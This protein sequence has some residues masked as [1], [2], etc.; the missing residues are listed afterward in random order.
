[1]VLLTM[2][3]V[4]AI[5]VSIINLEGW[6]LILYKLSGGSGSATKDIAT[7]QLINIRNIGT[8]EQTTNNTNYRPVTEQLRLFHDART[9]EMS[10]FAIDEHE[11]CRAWADVAK[12]MQTEYV[13]MSCDEQGIRCEKI[14]CR[15]SCD[16]VSIP[17]NEVPCKM[18]QRRTWYD[19][20]REEYLDHSTT[21][22]NRL[23]NEA[24]FKMF[25]FG[26]VHDIIAEYVDQDMVYSVLDLLNNNERSSLIREAE[27]HQGVLFAISKDHV[28]V[29][30]LM[31]YY[32]NIATGRKDYAYVSSPINQTF[33]EKLPDYIISEAMDQLYKYDDEVDVD[34]WYST[35]PSHPEERKVSTSKF[36][37]K[38]SFELDLRDEVLMNKTNVIDYKL[39]GISGDDRSFILSLLEGGL[40]KEAIKK[41][42]SSL[43]LDGNR[44]IPSDTEVVSSLADEYLLEP[45]CTRAIKQWLDDLREMLTT[46][47]ANAEYEEYEYDVLRQIPMV[48]QGYF[49]DKMIDLVV[50]KVDG[51]RVGEG[52][53]SYSFRKLSFPKL[54]DIEK[55]DRVSA[56][57][58][59]LLSDEERTKILYRLDKLEARLLQSYKKPLAFDFNNLMGFFLKYELELEESE[60]IFEEETLQDDDDD[61]DDDEPKHENVTRQEAQQLLDFYQKVLVA[62][63][64][65]GGSEVARGRIYIDMFTQLDDGDEV[66]S[67]VENGWYEIKDILSPLGPDEEYFNWYNIMAY[68]ENIVTGTELEYVST[69]VLV[70]NIDMLERFLPHDYDADEASNPTNDEEEV[71][72][73][74]SVM[75]KIESVLTSKPHPDLDD[76]WKWA[77]LSDTM[78]F[79]VCDRIGYGNDLVSMLYKTHMH[80]MMIRVAKECHIVQALR[81]VLPHYDDWKE[82][83]RRDA[84]EYMVSKVSITY[85]ERSY[86][87]G[88]YIDA[89]YPNI[90]KEK[91][92]VVK[93]TTY[94]ERLF[95]GMLYIIGLLITLSIVKVCQIVLPKK[96]KSMKKPKHAKKKDK[97]SIYS[98]LISSAQ[99][100]HKMVL[101][102]SSKLCGII[103]KTPSLLL[104][105]VLIAFDSV[106]ESVR[107]TTNASLGIIKHL[108]T[109][110]YSI[111]R[112]GIQCLVVIP[113]LI[114]I[115]IGMMIR[116]PS[117]LIR[118]AMGTEH[119]SIEQPSNSSPQR[120]GAPQLIMSPSSA[121]S[122]IAVDEKKVNSL[123]EQNTIRKLEAVHDDSNNNLDEESPLDTAP[124]EEGVPSEIGIVN[125][126]LGMT[127]ETITEVSISSFNDKSKTSKTLSSFELNENDPLLI[128]LRS[129][130]A[131]IKGSVDEFFTWLVKY[132]NIESMMALKEAVSDD[133]YLNDT[134][135]IGD[136]SYGVKGFKLKSFRYAIL[137]YED[138]KPVQLESKNV[139][140]NPPE[141]LVCP[142]SLALMTNDPVVAADGITYERAS[143]EDWFEKSK[144]KISE[145]QKNLKQN[146]HSKSDQRVV[147][148]GVCSPVHG[149]KIENLLLVPNI[150]LRNMAR[151]YKEKKE[152]LQQYK[153]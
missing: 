66:K 104:A 4:F 126:S 115:G 71:G 95:E 65:E 72:V 1:M 18:F 109:S 7:N 70:R 87:R 89:M 108:Y 123:V 118:E 75:T 22:S 151:A 124:R 96:K 30:N 64:D 140:M 82:M 62:A 12:C 129:Q 5:I 10:I 127:R 6:N 39:S 59:S 90:Q 101:G 67:L 99:H 112:R 113:Q 132:E 21:I 85:D 43:N 46:L 68:Y 114:F 15:R 38:A 57:M 102:T 133:D 9:K 55:R 74:S 84:I 120:S 125:S 105:V 142:I 32:L 44:H 146:P 40:E 41:G 148:N 49:V 100:V 144:A 110:I 77:D 153:K 14:S 111:L 83:N 78:L 134:M 122:T 50:P 117:K 116:L 51:E 139:T 141:E 93:E 81:G 54:E 137:E 36:I 58:L 63:H 76:S 88:T 149:T 91:Q 16:I 52:Y 106:A 143:I 47:I 8:F 34:W 37:S 86:L 97:T 131:C 107:S 24:L 45:P 25:F 11:N 27:E 56:Y 103:W 98:H 28:N 80:G 119:V 19:D 2:F 3:S 33:Y 23:R 31:T 94:F 138:T 121:V 53:T 73:K 17:T 48:F 26:K 60:V 128:F 29:Y 13:M 147:D 79:D 135:R 69:S 130:E 150:S 152:G 42:V 145:A 92:T 61:D 35:W 20:L 136:R